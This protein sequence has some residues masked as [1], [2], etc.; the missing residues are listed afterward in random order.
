[1][2]FNIITTFEFLFTELTLVRFR[3]RMRGNM[4]SQI[5]SPIKFL[6]TVQ[7]LKLRRFM[8]PIS[9]LFQRAF[10]FKHLT[11]PRNC[12]LKWTDI[13]MDDFM[14]CQITTIWKSLGTAV[15]RT[16]EFLCL[17]TVDIN[18]LLVRN[19]EIFRKR[20]LLQRNPHKVQFLGRTVYVFT[21]RVGYSNSNVSQGSRSQ[22][23]KF[24]KVEDLD[25]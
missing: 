12:A 8:P 23:N 21:L 20:C 24:R 16:S 25:T 9:V 14:T 3:S 18:S 6:Q 5:S 4:T 10:S 1:M 19:L 15:M 22:K 17:N 2:L 11:A 13:R 7:T